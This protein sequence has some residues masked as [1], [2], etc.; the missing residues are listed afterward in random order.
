MKSMLRT[1]AIGTTLRLLAVLT[2]AALPPIPAKAAAGEATD[3]LRAAEIAFARSVAEHDRAA[4]AATIAEDA[5]F[6]G[7]GGPLRGRDAIVEAWAPFLAED[8]PRLEWH[9]EV[10]EVEDGG[11]FGITRGPYTYT[12]R[13]PDGEPV[14][15]QGTFTSVWRREGDGSWRV[16]FDSGCPPCPKCA[17]GDPP[18]DRR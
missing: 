10:A 14:T 8:G 4:F 5:I 17:A 13:G 1:P 6:L 15:E 2:L 18:A 3:S 16:V 9:P 11:D 7:A 12:G